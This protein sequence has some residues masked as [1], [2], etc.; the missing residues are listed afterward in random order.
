MGVRCATVAI[1]MVFTQYVGFLGGVRGVVV[2]T[3]LGTMFATVFDDSYL[4]IV[5]AFCQYKRVYPVPMGMARHPRVV[6][7]LPTFCS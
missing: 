1:C 5:C 2:S 7:V 3:L 6:N 4:V